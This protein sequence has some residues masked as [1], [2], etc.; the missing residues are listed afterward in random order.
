MP[1]NVWSKEFSSLSNFSSQVGSKVTK[2]LPQD[3]DLL[4]C[5][6]TR[7]EYWKA[8]WEPDAFPLI[9]NPISKEK[10]VIFS[11]GVIT[12]NWLLSI[13]L[14]ETNK[15]ETIRLMRLSEILNIEPTTD[16]V[17]S[18]HEIPS[19]TV[20]NYKYSDKTAGFYFDSQSLMYKF[21]DLLKN[22]KRGGKSNEISRT[23]Q[24]V[25]E[26]DSYENSQKSGLNQLSINGNV[27]GSTIIIGNENKVQ[28]S[29]KKNSF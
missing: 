6:E 1:E 13:Y 5:F 12:K 3:D 14:N 4:F 28:N 15:S 21:E 24:V 17:G 22:A 7:M 29:Q 9:D 19:V 16:S 25:T 20:T 10:F 27:T 18:I 2:N 23:T 26:K 11:A 8:V